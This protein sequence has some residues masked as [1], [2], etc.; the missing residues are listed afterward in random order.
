MA[1]AWL[2]SLN[3]TW[4]RCRLSLTNSIRQ[5]GAL[6]CSVTTCRLVRRMTAI[7]P[8]RVCSKVRW[9]AC[10]TTYS[11][12]PP[13]T[14]AIYYQSRSQTTSQLITLQAKSTMA[15]ES[16]RRISLSERFGLWLA[17]HPFN[18][19]KYLAIVEHWLGSARSASLGSRANSGSRSAVGSDTWFAQRP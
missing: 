8:S 13:L 4:V 7:S 9:R 3:Q 19:E 11:F 12:M 6:L 14:G 18:Q 10:R 5:Q 2:N 1:C 17:F 15:R 16:K